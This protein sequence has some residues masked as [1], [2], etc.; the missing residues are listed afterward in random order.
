MRNGMLWFDDH[1]NLSIADKVERAA[2]H[3]EDKLGQRP[4]VCYI[5]PSMMVAAGLHGPATL[6]GVYVKC[7]N[8]VLP[9]HFWLGVVEPQPEEAA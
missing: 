6:A 2:R 8:N 3:Y 1:T 9:N 7:T 4:T 5:H